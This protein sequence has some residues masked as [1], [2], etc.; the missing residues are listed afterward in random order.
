MKYRADIDGL[1]AVAI[2]SVVL[3]HLTD[4]ASGG[5]VGVDV[6]FVI[7][8]FLITQIIHDEITAGRFSIAVFYERRIRRIFPALFVVLAVT[9]VVGTII[10]LPNELAVFGRSLAATTLFVSNIFFLSQASYFD[11]A[12]ATKPLLHTWSLAV[13][14]QFYLLFPLFLIVI[15]NVFKSRYL[16]CT[17]I[18]AGL[19]LLL[20][21]G[22]VSADPAAA[23]YLAPARAWELLAG[24]LIALGAFP[25]S[26][27]RVIR[28]TLGF[29]GMGL[30][31]V[32]VFLYSRGTPFPGL[33]A[34]PP[35]IGAAL[36]IYSG[37]Q[38]DTLVARLLGVRPVVFLGL[39]SYSLYLWHWPI[40]AFSRLA[41]GR[42]F[43]KPEELCVIVASLAAA[44]LSWRYVEQPLRRR[45]TGIAWAG[46]LRLSAGVMVALCVL[47]AGLMGSDGLPQ[48]FSPRVDRLAAYTNYDP[49][50]PYREGVCFLTDFRIH[51]ATIDMKRCLTPNPRQPN[52]LLIGDSHA[53]H[54][55]IGLSTAYPGIH[56]LQ[57]TASGCKPVL[58]GPG[59]PPCR[60]LRSF[61]LHD[62]IPRMRP[63][64]ILISA[65]WTA[66]DLKPLLATIDWLRSARR[67]IVV[68]GPIV[69]YQSNL[70]RLL[71]VGV[72]RGNPLLVDQLRLPT[73]ASID[74]T[75]E[76]ALVG[77]GV[78][79]IS[80]Y[81]A[82]CA[83]QGCVT[84]TDTG[85]PLQFD[86]THLTEAGS[87]WLAR[88]WKS[89]GPFQRPLATALPAR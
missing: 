73:Q 30:I 14:E 48:R 79:Y 33:A 81:R 66:R 68:F 21:V 51:V 28:E 47:G 58:D 1:R 46:L 10:L 87:V 17:W 72:A 52:Y 23:F 16:L 41:L 2:A 57:A 89:A 3:F 67:P 78:T 34:V 39:V 64:A 44:T 40:I 63:D 42:D 32:S 35:A 18:F 86:A 50:K 11:A 76:S 83:Q 55:W 15:H 80:I 12:E 38:R 24:C 45:G 82:I 6:F 29:A 69:E 19:S 75:F 4:Y 60:A 62:Y 26:P 59:E 20:S 36:V 56:F 71:A 31:V 49:A 7:S 77:V 27:H 53:A 25:A 84:I 74:R 43:T 65:A 37:A 88:H 61:M 5:Y 54:L 13:E 70:P 22:L 85:I 9:T 8:G